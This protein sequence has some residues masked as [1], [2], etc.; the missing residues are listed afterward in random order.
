MI[1]Y[2]GRLFR[3]VRTE[4]DG[5]VGEDT[6]F[7]YEQRGM[8]LLASY[9]GGDI[10]FGSIVGTVHEDGSLSFLYHHITKSG[11]LRSGRCESQPVVLPGGRL[12]LHERWEWHDGR[13][14]GSSV[15]EEL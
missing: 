14:A 9:A 1:H 6:I 12:R 2:G 13:G 10:E 15:I 3:L 5:D 7:R 8:I 4:G 11:A